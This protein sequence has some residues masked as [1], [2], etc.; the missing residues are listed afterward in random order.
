MKHALKT[1]FQVFLALILLPVGTVRAQNTNQRD[2]Q[3]DPGREESSLP[4]EKKTRIDRLISRLSAKSY[5]TRQNAQEKLLEIGSP[6]VPVLKKHLST[7]N[8]E[9]RNRLLTILRNLGAWKAIPELAK[10][11]VEKYIRLLK[12]ERFFY[13]R[14]NSL[15]FR[16]WTFR[17]Q[18]RNVFGRNAPEKPSHYLSPS[19]VKL[20][21]KKADRSDETLMKNI[22]FLLRYAPPEPSASSLARLDGSEAAPFR[23]I[24][25]DS[26]TEVIPND[27]SPAV[28][29]MI[30][31]G[32]TNAGPKVQRKALKLAV[33]LPAEKSVP[34]LLN[35][36]Q[37]NR[38]DV[39][40]QAYFSLREITG[41]DI[42][43][44]AWWKSA[45]RKKKV[46]Q[47]KNWWRE[48]R[49]NITSGSDAGE[50]A[51]SET[52]E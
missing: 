34:K 46:Q 51:T 41:Q 29:R 2:Q 47:W 23:S 38:A 37:S 12:Q 10:R 3:T 9:T 21:L 1:T 36:L 33:H 40:Y 15:H 22:A 13:D 45:R 31:D 8:P 25:F 50:D 24:L 20:L 30:L 11:R 28:R 49:K 26:L 16:S 48:N 6:A 7:D 5:R 43:F 44:N 4:D 52:N 32:M 27:P 14:N 39:R 18:A 42:Y 35:A 17:K 19:M